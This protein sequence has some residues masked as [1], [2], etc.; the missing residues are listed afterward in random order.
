MKRREFL[1]RAGLVA[2]WAAIPVAITAC[3]D[4]DENP[5]QPNPNDVVG[6]VSTVAGHSHGVRI[7]EAQIDAGAAVMLTLSS[8]SGHIHTVALNADEVGDIG[9]GTEV[10]KESTID[11]GHAHQV[12]FN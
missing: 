2:T 7:T 3:G 5:S 8:S 10:S 9:D 12:T 11:Q 1:A 4:D 6:D